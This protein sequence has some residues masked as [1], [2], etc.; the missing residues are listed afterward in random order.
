MIINFNIIFLRLK[1]LT[2]KYLSN[3]A[4]GSHL[5]KSKIDMLARFEK[6]RKVCNV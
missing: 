3:V 5:E 2:T 1:E 4:E 6:W